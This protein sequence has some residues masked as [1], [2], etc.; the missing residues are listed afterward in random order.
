MERKAITASYLTAKA[1]FR[2]G[3]S[4]GDTHTGR[5]RWSASVPG[6]FRDFHEPFLNQLRG[7]RHGISVD[8]DSG[9]QIRVP[10]VVSSR[11]RATQ[12]HLHAVLHQSGDQ[13]F[14]G[15]AGR[16][17]TIRIVRPVV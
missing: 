17:V 16:D 8:F 12:L 6:S 13:L 10:P 9:Q 3:K 5:R 2:S 7:S 14:V 1:E 11:G 15:I 4:T